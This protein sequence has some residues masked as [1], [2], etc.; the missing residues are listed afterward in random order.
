VKSNIGPTAAGL[1][2]RSDPTQTPNRIEAIPVLWDPD[3]VDVTANEA[4]AAAAEAARGSG[5]QREAEEF[6]LAYL[7]A[8]PMPADKVL[9]AAGPMASRSGPWNGPKAVYAWCRRRTPS[10]TAGPG[11]CPDD[12]GRQPAPSFA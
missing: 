3:P 7:D 5:Q 10:G 8:G 9:A 1:A 4:I 6:L 11:D 12:E 2:Y